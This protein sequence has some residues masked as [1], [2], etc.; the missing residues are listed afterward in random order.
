MFGIADNS[1]VTIFEKICRANEVSNSEQEMVN[2]INDISFQASNKG[3]KQQTTNWKKDQ[4][5]MRGKDKIQLDEW[6][7]AGSVAMD[8]GVEEECPA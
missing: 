2:K 6:P 5:K 3:R 4:Q 7:T 8:K 1:Y